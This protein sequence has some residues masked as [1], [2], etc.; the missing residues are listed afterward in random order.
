MSRR[1]VVSIDTARVNELIGEFAGIEGKVPVALSRAINRSTS[2][3]KTEAVRQVRSEYTARAGTINETIKVTRANTNNLSAKIES[4]GS[5]LR[6]KE[7]RVNPKKP[8]P[9]RRSPI[10]VEVRRGSK[11]TINGAFVQRMP[12]GSVGVYAR[13]GRSRLPIRQLFGPAVPVML[14]NDDVVAA[15]QSRAEQV[16]EQRI[17]HELN[18]VLG[19]GR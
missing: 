6:M 18:R 2:A 14:N 5:S 13:T 4:R 16:L 1:G 9:R 7:F 17:G 11:K 12:N 3:A 15:V 10:T 19:G 8:S